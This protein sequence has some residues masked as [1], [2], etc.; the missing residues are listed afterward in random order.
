M[1]AL[2]ALLAVAAVSPAF[3]SAELAGKKNCL[4][5]H[6]TDKK[7]VGPSYKEV[8]AKYK[9]QKDAVAMLATKIQKGGVGVWGQVP[10]PANNV[11]PDEA[12]Q[13]ATWVLSI[14]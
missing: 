8:A 5:C 9:G 13:L 7:L 10:M 14:K 4:A 1:K 2:I 12:K 11:T 3:A 6:A